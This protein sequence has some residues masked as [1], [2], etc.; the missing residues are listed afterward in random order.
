MSNKSIAFAFLVL[1][2]SAMPAGAHAFLDHAEPRV[3]N[4]VRSSPSAVTLWFTQKLEPAF[5][6]AQVTN[7]SGAVVSSGTSVSGTVMRVGV[8]S[9]PPGT[10]RV[11]W[12]VLSVDTHTTEGSFSFRVGQ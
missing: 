12:K 4:T 10:Y 2:A 7:A 9:L 5:S 3:G 6:S 8:R 11:H 1:T